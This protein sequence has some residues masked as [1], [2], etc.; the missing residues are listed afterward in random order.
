VCIAESNI[1]PVSGLLT[2]IP[3]K[4][5]RDITGIQQCSTKQLLGFLVHLPV[6][7]R[8]NPILLKHG[9][10]L[11]GVHVMVMMVIFVILLFCARNAPKN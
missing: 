4:I 7:I 11:D 10:W 8:I 1:R 3:F 9:L 5:T 6:D 2:S